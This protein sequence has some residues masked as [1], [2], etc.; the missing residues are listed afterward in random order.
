MELLLIFFFFYYKGED[1]N[2]KEESVTNSWLTEQHLSQTHSGMSEYSPPS[3][4]RVPG[5]SHSPGVPQPP[6]EANHLHL[7]QQQWESGITHNQPTPVPCQ[8]KLGKPIKAQA[9]LTQPQNVVPQTESRSQQTEILSH[10]EEKQQTVCIQ[11]ETTVSCCTTITLGSLSPAAG[12][13]T[14]HVQVA[15]SAE[16]DWT[17]SKQTSDSKADLDSSCGK[18][19]QDTEPWPPN[20]YTTHTSERSDIKYQTFF[21][22]GQFHSFQPGE[23]L[24]NGVRAVPSCQEESED[25]SS[26]D[27]E[28]K[29]IIEL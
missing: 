26:S 13:S 10:Q 8:S 24:N 1:L 11:Q 14:N 16:A 4:Q 19:Q 3:C 12:T 6:L 28:G 9:Q 22:T 29:L 17:G 21:L 15:R 20:D 18:P 23:G 2:V 7:S 27:E 5:T 25:T